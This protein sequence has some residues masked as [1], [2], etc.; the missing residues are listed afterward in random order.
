MTPYS[1]LMASLEGRPTDRLPNTCI[2][3]TFAAQLIGVPYGQYVSR[4][5]VLAKG[6]YQCAQQ[7]GLDVLSVI[8]DPAREAA[9][10]GAKVVIP[11]DDVPFVAEPLIKTWADLSALKPRD[12]ATCE[13][14]NDRLEAVRLLRGMAGDSYPVMGWVEAPLAEACDLRDVSTVMMDLFDEPEAVQELLEICLEQAILFAEAQIQAGAQIIGIGDAVASLIGPS[15]YE[16]FALPYEQRLIAAIK[17]RGIKTKLH[18]CGNISSLLPQLKKTGAD[19]IDL[20]WMVDFGTAVR[21]FGNQACASGNFDPVEV[22]LQGSRAQVEQAV[23][24][25]AALALPNT[26]IQAGCEVPRH[27]P[28][29]N[30]LAVS[31]TLK[32]IA[33]QHENFR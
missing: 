1:R 17:A 7:F 26:H 9:G 10:F 29:D 13:R 16:E 25:C 23:R 33:G 31:Q 5:D 6:V 22:L 27:T 2:V 18:I 8:S 14:M 15:L 11:E 4:A 3:M 32:A 12:P 21:T 28:H 24:D 19:I 20:D 30:L